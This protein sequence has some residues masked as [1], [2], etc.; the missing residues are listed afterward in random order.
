MSKVTL[1]DISKILGISTST[2]SKALKNYSDINVETKLK[3]QELAKKLNFTPNAFAQS[4]RSR[5]TK[6]IGILVPELVHHFFS[7]VI[8]GAIHE[9]EKHGYLVIVLQTHECYEDE[10]K[11][12]KLLVD[13]NIDGILLSLSDKT[14]KYDHIKNIIDEGMPVV[15]F[16][17]ITHLIDCPKVIINDRK[18]AFSATEHLIKTG[19]KKIAHITGPLK[20]KTTIDRFMGYKIALETYNMPFDKSLIYTSENLFFEDGYRLA[21]QMM[22]EHPDIDGVFAFIDLVAIG[23]LKGL[24]EQKIKVPKQVAVIGFSN[25]LMSKTTT[26]SL[27]TIDQPGY[28]MGKQAFQLLLK[29]LNQKREGKVFTSEIVEIPT[30]VVVRKSTNAIIDNS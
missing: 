10:I 26:P 30:R 8:D 21:G 17:K 22:A 1:K 5:E 3:V 14:V 9:A 25:W 27:T 13:K 19:C 28:D 23:V 16:D 2:V 7:N 29:N 15:L 4:L 11:Q 18:A 12:L 24:R 20:P 6:I